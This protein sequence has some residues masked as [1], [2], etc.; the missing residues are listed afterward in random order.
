MGMLEPSKIFAG[1]LEGALEKN[2][3]VTAVTWTVPHDLPYF[4]GHFP[5]SPIFPAVGIIDASLVLLQKALSQPAL[6][7]KSVPLAKFLSPITP[8]Q[9]VRIEWKTGGEGEWQIEWKEP[10]TQR[11]LA[12]LRLYA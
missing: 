12:T 9:P 2:G 3:D 10:S 4:N 1:I 11:L 6:V 8:D 5:Q 7:L